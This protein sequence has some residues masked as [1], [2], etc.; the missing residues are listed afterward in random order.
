MA[1]FESLQSPKMNFRVDDVIG[2]QKFAGGYFETNC[3]KTIKFL[4]T[5]RETRRVEKR[6]EIVPVA[7]LAQEVEILSSEKEAMSKRIAE[8][9]G[10]V[11]QLEASRP[12]K[13]GPK[14]NKG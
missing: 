7:E 4:E 14:T 2:K 10:D 8:L 6:K 5:L 9:E 1:L 11:A 13:P 3:E 12:A